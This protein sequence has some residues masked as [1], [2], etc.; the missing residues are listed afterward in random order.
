[1]ADR[2]S[3]PAEVRRE[4]LVEAGHRCAIQTCRNTADI[5]L[6]HIVPWE[7]CNAHDAANLIAL[8][9]NCHRL[10][11][12]GRIDRKSLHRYKEICQK[13]TRPP[14]RHIERELSTE[15]EVKAFIKFDP[16]QPTDIRDA[17]NI[18]SLS[19]NG[20]LDFT[21]TFTEDFDDDRYVVN[22]IANGSVHFAVT[23]QTKGSVS[24]RLMS[25]CPNIVRL[26]FRY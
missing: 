5:D 15:S 8:C 13:L 26:E 23:A 17:R 18:S 21:F 25:P 20:A 16:N 9:P 24:L 2:P 3:I 22:A 14:G 7:D 4:V 1:M 6:H 12:R 10:A 11:D 19:D